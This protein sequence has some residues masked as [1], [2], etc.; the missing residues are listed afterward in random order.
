MNRIQRLS[1]AAHGPVRVTLN[2]PW[3]ADTDLASAS[4]LLAPQR[5]AYEVPFLV[6]TSGAALAHLPSIQGTRRISYTGAWT[7]RGRH[8]DGFA[9]A[10]ALVTS[11][12]FNA[13]APFAFEDTVDESVTTRIVGD[14][15]GDSGAG[16]PANETHV[17][18]RTK[19]A[20]AW[21]RGAALA[22]AAI[23]SAEWTRRSVAPLWRWVAWPVV[24]ALALVRVSARIGGWRRIE[25]LMLDLR[26][27]W[28]G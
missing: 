26:A 4:A 7:R 28:R 13:V 22:R 5:C 15:E 2:P 11:P 27:G 10:M 18:V 3:P 8:E 12:L 20:A 16:H 21:V 6:S 25:M 24:I 14:T 9:S 23:A 1:P 19:P 17:I